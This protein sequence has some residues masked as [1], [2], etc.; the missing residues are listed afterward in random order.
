MLEH[1]KALGLHQDLTAA[2][3]FF[4]Y[5][6]TGW[7][8]WNY[9]VGGLLVGATV[10]LYD[11]SAVHPDTGALWRLAE[12]AGVTYAGTGAPYLLACMKE[13][14]RPAAE[15]DLS[16]L[17]G[18]G[19]TGSP[20]P[21]EGFRWVYDA[22]ATE[23]QD[24]I[25]GSFSGGTDLC[26]GFVGPVPLLPV[27]AGII[28]G[29]CLGAKVEAFDPAGHPVIG[30]VGELVLT[31]PMPSMPVGFWNDPDGSA[32][33]GQL[34]RRLP[35]RLAARRLDHDPARRR[36]RDLR[37]VR[38]DAEPR[39]RPDGHQRV[40]PGGGAAARGGRQPGGGHREAGPGRPADPV[41]GAGP[42]ARPGRRSSPGR[43]GRCCGPS[44][45][46]GTCRTRSTRCRASRGRC[47]ARSSR[48]RSARSCRAPRW[49]T[50]PI[51]T[52]SPT[53]RCSAT[54]HQPTGRPS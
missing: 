13:G 27:R 52:R 35:G 28:A 5:T 41:R 31:Q 44:C 50:R 53:P 15:H 9:L 51:R 54:S 39:R 29:P 49:R 33:P 11:G 4:W 3:T 14:M 37:P 43:S 47:P 1:L 48:F 26:T 17:R 7:M 34:F 42:G 32:V 23:G 45:R 12:E 16:R 21:P 24:L 10:V 38:R 36:L 40:L 25:L 30:E 2:D 22:V 46:R 6:T 19:S 20:L 18:V 8:M